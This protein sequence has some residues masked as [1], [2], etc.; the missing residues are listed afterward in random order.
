MPLL[1]EAK[2]F[3]AFEGVSFGAVA[4]EPLLPKKERMSF[5]DGPEGADLDEEAWLVD[6]DMVSEQRQA[7]TRRHA[8]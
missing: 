3:E 2:C 7:K 6:G 5:P 4:V 1:G 8:L